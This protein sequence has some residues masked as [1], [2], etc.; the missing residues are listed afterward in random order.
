MATSSPNHG[1]FELSDTFINLEDTPMDTF[2][3]VPS[4]DMDFEELKSRLQEI[5]LENTAFETR[6]YC[7][8]H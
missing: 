3:E 5:Y 2:L 8:K 7:Y 4:G 6:K 1:S